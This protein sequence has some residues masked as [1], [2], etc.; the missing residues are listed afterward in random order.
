MLSRLREIV[1][2]SSTP[3]FGRMT[4]AAAV[5]LV[6]GLGL[7]AFVIWAFAGI[8]EEVVEGDTRRFDREVLLW[9]HAHFPA[10]LEGPMRAV[11]ALGYYRVVLPLLLVSAAAFYLRGWRLSAVL[12]AVSTAG[13]M[14]LT[15]V[16]KAVFQRSRPELFQS[17]YEAGFYS[18]PSGHATVAVGFYGMLTLILA[19]RAR[20]ALRWTIAALGAALVVLIGFS[21]LYLGVHYPTDVLAGYLSA[22]L[23]VVFVGV[24]YAAWLSV[25]GLRR[26][27]G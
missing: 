27:G 26:K 21:R 7:S 5:W 6:A 9:I 15:T 8:A 24:L 17:G 20:G 25:R 16:L 11:T 22:P 10:W 23:W 12:L 14:F 18:F 1:P 4:L 3:L 19:Y 13:G 2:V